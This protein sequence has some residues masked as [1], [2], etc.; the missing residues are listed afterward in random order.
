[1]R[2]LSQNQLAAL[3]Q[4]IIN[5]CFLIIV[6]VSSPDLDAVY[7]IFSVLNSRGLDLSYPDILKA[8]IINAIPA[9]ERDNYASKWEEL[10]TSL[11]NDVF[12]ELFFH[13][14]A[15]FSKDRQRKGMIEEF[16]EYIYP[17]YP[18]SMTP[19]DFIDKTLEPYARALDNI[20]KTNHRGTLTKEI[21]EMF[22]WLN[23]LD[24]GRWIPPT[25]YYYT[26]YS[27]QPQSVLHFLTDLERLVIC[28]MVC[29]TP[30][31]RRIDRY[32]ELIKAVSENKD[33]FL[34][35]SP[36]QL[37]PGE[38]RE[39]LRKL[40][41]DMYDLHYVCRYILVRSDAAFSEG[42][43]T[44]D[45]DK[46]SIEHILPRHPSD[47]SNWL[48]SFP[49]KELREKYVHRLGNLVLLSRT[50]NIAAENFDFEQKKQKYFF[51]N[52]QSTPFVTTNELRS[53]S[54]WTPA[55]IEQRQN[56]QISKLRELWR[57]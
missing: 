20:V 50:R 21:S 36:L 33:L 10:E 8:D 56:R 14:R 35:G 25:L 3:T 5:R 48:K 28:F 23:H 17:R 29:K 4:F 24:R 7:R 46:L 16:H 42:T 57:L 32:C 47:D 1:L 39:F 54:E 18:Q 6:A 51:F 11:G 31:Y 34:P 30:P 43:A 37:S 12:E 41:S 13:L 55:I 22:K 53:F 19:Q 2:K 26:K 49:T 38:C 40:N 44:Y 27:R 45:I 52:G 15:I 9:G